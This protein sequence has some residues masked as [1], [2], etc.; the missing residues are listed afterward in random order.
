MRTSQGF[1]NE[2][3]SYLRRT[4][5]EYVCIKQ[6]RIS[7]IPTAERYIRAWTGT[8]LKKVVRGKYRKRT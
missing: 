5:R 1:Q 3:I 7:T 8:R 4:E 2:P 6:P